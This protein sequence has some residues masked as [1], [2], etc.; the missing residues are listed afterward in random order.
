[1]NPA[2]YVWVGEADDHNE[3]G[4]FDFDWSTYAELKGEPELADRDYRDADG[5]EWDEL[6]GR[7][8]CCHCGNRRIRYWMFF[9]HTPTG[10]VVAVGTKCASTLSLQSREDIARRAEIHRQRLDEKLVEWR[11]E[12]ERHERA[13]TDLL[14][15]EDAGGGSGARGSE[16]VDSLLR[17]ARRHGGLSEAQVEAV[18]NGIE[19]REQR[20]R[21]RAERDA[22]MNDPEPATVVTGRIEVTGRVLTIKSQPSNFGYGGS[23]TKMLV[24]DD[25][26]FK[27]WGTFPEALTDP[28]FELAKQAGLEGMEL[29][30]AGLVKSG[31]KVR[32]GF[33][34]AVEKSRDDETFGFVKRPSK[35]RVVD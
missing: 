23:V 3:H 8:A 11:A 21:E 14:A 15:R 34:A 28:I 5:I 4:T 33:T 32:V 2:D 16:F 12:D 18:L 10:K 25:R 9:V 20:R 17:Y 1:M 30:C 19:T 13:Y 31:A 27:V 6:T 24:L 22:L 29:S 35:A 7:G 26:G